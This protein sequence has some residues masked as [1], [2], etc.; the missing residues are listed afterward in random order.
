M[1]EPTNP[2]LVRVITDVVVDGEL[3]ESR[4]QELALEI[5]NNTHV[6]ILEKEDDEIKGVNKFFHAH[7]HNTTDERC[8]T[9][10]HFSRDGRSG[11]G[12]YNGD[13]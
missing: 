13:F 6:L 12:L 2:T 7:I 4:M 10:Y 1:A 8:N 5:S 9:C 11:Q 3:N